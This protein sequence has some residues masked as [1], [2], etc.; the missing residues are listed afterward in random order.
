[1]LLALTDTSCSAVAA[2][3]AELRAQGRL[4][5]Q[6]ADEQALLQVVVSSRLKTLLWMG[7][8]SAHSPLRSPP[9]HAGHDFFLTGC[10]PCQRSCLA[11]PAASTLTKLTQEEAAA[12]A[13]ANYS[14]CFFCTICCG[15]PCAAAAFNLCCEASVFWLSKIQVLSSRS[16]SFQMYFHGILRDRE[17]PH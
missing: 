16:R 2:V 7:R 4:Q 3:F 14:L 15:A 10:R 17:W 8:S 6:A 11:A 13:H 9:T 12:K 1:M 5:L